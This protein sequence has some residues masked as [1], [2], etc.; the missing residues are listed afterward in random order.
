MLLTFLTKRLLRFIPVFLGLSVAV[1][2]L[3]RL[4][5]GDAV[6]AMLGNLQDPETASQMR[7]LFG[8]DKPIH[9]QYARWLS[10]VARG[11]LGVSIRT[12]RPVTTEIMSVLPATAQLALMAGVG[13]TLLGIVLGLLGATRHGERLDTLVAVMGY[14]GISI[15]N[16]WL[17]TLLILLFGVWLNVLPSGGYTKLTND[18]LTSMEDTVLPAITL[19]LPFAAVVMRITRSSTLEVLGMEYVFVARAKGLAERVVVL[20]HVFKNA[21]ITVVTVA[22]LQF[23]FLLGGSVVVEAVFIRP[24]VGRLLLVAIQQRDYA[25]VQ[26]ITLFFGLVF[27]TSNLIVDVLYGILDPRI[28]VD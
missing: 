2:F 8:L 19:G 15:P 23:G 22:G 9:V 1:F 26:G 6:D 10:N 16:F 17:G 12:G 3:L 24:G 14:V 28:R 11:D 27:M 20:R 21:L 25:V 5:P 18:F 13:G 4:V 7:E